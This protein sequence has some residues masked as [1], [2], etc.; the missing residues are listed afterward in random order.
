[1]SDS[2]SEK[3]RPP[4]ALTLN[5]KLKE[6]FGEYSEEKYEGM[7]EKW[8]LIL[9]KLDSLSS[10]K[11]TVNDAPIHAHL[12]HWIGCGTS[13]NKKE[14]VK[15]V[16]KDPKTAQEIQDFAQWTLFNKDPES[17][18]RHTPFKIRL[19]RG[20]KGL[21]ADFKIQPWDSLTKNKDF[22]QTS[23]NPYADYGF[24]HGSVLE[25]QVPAI[26]IFT[27]YEAYPAFNIRRPEQEFILNE[28]GIQGATL[29]SI[30][31]KKPTAE[32]IKKLKTNMPELETIPQMSNKLENGNKVS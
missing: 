23:A 30:D 4:Q 3:A 24:K 25:I 32:E 9:F 10:D 17:T 12:K 22:A 7:M 6:R 2:I 27:Y 8:R 19:F 21:S 18:Q 11:I 5:N 20:V 1:M 15:A 31:G 16:K 28:R 29:V 26:N 13:S 14:M